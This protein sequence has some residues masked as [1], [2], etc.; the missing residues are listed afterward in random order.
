MKNWP[1]VLFFLVCVS[2]CGW[3]W[4]QVTVS[5]VVMP[6]NMPT[7]DEVRQIMLDCEQFNPGRRCIFVAMTVPDFSE[8]VGR[9]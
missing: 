1:T 7:Q 4:Y 9:E 8:S 6:H 2:V 5:R 3:L